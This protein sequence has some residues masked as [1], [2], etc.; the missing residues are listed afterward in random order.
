MKDVAGML[1]SLHYASRF[2]LHERR[3]EPTK[4]LEER[5]EAWEERNAAAFMQG[6]YGTDGIDRLLPP[7]PEDREAVRL[8]FELEKAF[9]ELSYEQDFRPE[10]AGIPQAALRRLLTQPVGALLNRSREPLS[11][12]EA[13]AP[14]MGVRRRL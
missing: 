2:V 9:Y 12:D 1:R 6:Y 13:T 8:A 3:E 14:G 5:A 11:P 7:A 10:W 4:E